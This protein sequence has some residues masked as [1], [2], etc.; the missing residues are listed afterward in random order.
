MGKKQTK[1]D[2]AD[3]RKPIARCLREFLATRAAPRTA[4][5]ESVLLKSEDGGVR[6][7]IPA[8]GREQ[9]WASK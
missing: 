6:S 9:W 8:H 5:R 7:E 1:E 4:R 2:L 3:I